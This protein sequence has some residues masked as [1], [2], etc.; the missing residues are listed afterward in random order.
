VTINELQ[1]AHAFE[2][3]ADVGKISDW[4]ELYNTGPSAYQLLGTRLVINGVRHMIDAP[5][6]I[7][8]DSYLV[9]WCDGEPNL[10]PDH[11]RATLPRSGA[12]VQLI[13]S[14]GSTIMD[15][16]S[17]TELIATLSLGREQKA[18]GNFKI[19][20]TPTPGAANR[21][22]G[23]A[24]TRTA[25]PLPTI[26]PGIYFRPFE[27]D[28]NGTQYDEI[29]YTTDGSVP[30]P[31]S[32]RWRSPMEVHETTT[33]RAIA[34]QK[35]ALPS[36]EMI[37]S[38][39]FD[40]SLDH[41][42]HLTV[43]PEDLWNDSTGIYTK[44]VFSNNT[45]TGK[46]WERPVV[47]QFLNADPT[48]TDEIHSIV[49]GIRIS[50]SGS[51][52]MAKRSFKLFARDEY[53]GPG[54]G[55]PFPNGEIYTEAI[56]RADASPNGY[57]HN[58]IM[59]SVVCKGGLALDVQ[60]STTWPVYLNNA[61]WG[62][63]RLMPPKD[64]EW[65]AALSRTKDLDVLEG[66][67]LRPISGSNAD[68]Y[69]AV[70]LI[71]RKAPMK[72]IEELIDMES[73]IDLACLD[74]YT[75]RADHDLNVRCYRPHIDGEPGRWRWIL[76]DM[77]LWSAP[78][79]NSVLRMCMSTEQEAPYLSS[80]L[81]H[82]EIQERLLMRMV[83]LQATILNPFNLHA[84]ADSIYQANSAVLAE[85]QKRWDGKLDRPDP[86]HALGEVHEMIAERGPYL[87][88]YLGERTRHE[89]RIV[90]I[91]APDPGSGHL[92][93]N[94]REMAPGRIRIHSFK[95]IP[96]T[97]EARPSPEFTFTEWN[98]HSSDPVLTCYGTE[99]QSVI[100]GGFAPS[101]RTHQDI[102]QQGVEQEPAVGIP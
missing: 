43:D 34:Y 63:Y 87:M 49:A 22:P 79:E 37:A 69:H 77:D 14:D 6:V 72:E 11:I 65:L 66:P 89:V 74:L 84:I 67:A 53:A 93:I 54:I 13:A 28:L 1:A 70:E 88:H 81:T 102:L 12:T 9:L 38:Y 99:P 29:R 2:P 61:Y 80:L 20:E 39:I 75:G 100:E 24:I 33:I 82:P 8:A 78:K 16:V 35:D 92:L 97:I 76:Y 25:T 86:H 68:L 41:A 45:R 48:G 21:Y 15:S 51:R 27:L 64:E 40:P 5:I 10:G 7:P 94:G 62:T 32:E 85:D 44:G 96:T 57:L 3:N 23:Y 83:A 18:D 59:E 60:P 36:S 19:F 30:S 98:S 101:L 42:I 91:I 73:L 71:E 52:G 31:Q 26:Q 4:V 50:G 56:L 46:G 55:F 95:N 90:T 17:Y 58:T 47:I